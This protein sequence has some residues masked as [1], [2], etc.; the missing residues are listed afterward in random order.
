MTITIIDR[1]REASRHTT[2]ASGTRI[3]SNQASRRSLQ[4]INTIVLHQTWQPS[5]CARGNA[6]D[7]YDRVIAHYVVTA[8]GTILQVRNLEALLNDSWGGRAVH[9]EFVGNFV[10]AEGSSG[11]EQPTISQIR[12]GRAL[13]SHLFKGIPE[14]ALQIHHIVAHAQISNMHRGNCPG[15]HIWRNIAK[16]A[17][18]MHGLGSN[19]RGARPV[20]PDWEDPRFDI[21][22]IYTTVDPFQCRSSQTEIPD[23][24]NQMPL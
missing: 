10:N 16:W 22:F 9:I 6:V 11:T 3:L 24:Q 8:N 19:P 12:S 15:P 18:D 14:I 13:V 23:Q 2:N 17:K 1:T 5:L 21:L 20:S 7:L 4:R